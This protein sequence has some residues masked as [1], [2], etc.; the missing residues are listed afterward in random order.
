MCVPCVER[1]ML[2]PT[3][4][5]HRVFCGQLRVCLR[6]RSILV[7]PPL[8]TPWPCLLPMDTLPTWKCYASKFA[9]ST[10][11]VSRSTRTCTLQDDS[12]I[13]FFS[14]H[15]PLLHRP[16]RE[17][18]PLLLLSWFLSL[19]PSLESTRVDGSGEIQRGTK[20]KGV[21][22]TCLDE[23]EVQLGW[24]GRVFSVRVHLSGTVQLH[25]R[26]ETRAGCQGASR[27]ERKETNHGTDCQE[28]W[29]KR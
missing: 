12:F 6:W 3:S 26:T 20:E 19:S 11:V 22:C 13:P 28:T 27:V 14:A 5:N 8:S 25:E 15:V 29:T 2:N 10:R 7:S 17:Q 18:T 1:K 4:G 23:D 16:C 21:A 9:T 24:I